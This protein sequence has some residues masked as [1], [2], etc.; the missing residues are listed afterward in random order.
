MLIKGDP[1]ASAALEEFNR[2]DL[3]GSFTA[4]PSD[5][6]IDRLQG[7]MGDGQHYVAAQVALFNSAPDLGGPVDIDGRLYLL[8]AGADEAFK[9][10]LVN[11]YAGHVGVSQVLHAKVEAEASPD[12]PEKA[13]AMR[14][15]IFD[16]FAAS[17][18]GEG[19]RLI[20]GYSMLASAENPQDHIGF[21]FAAIALIQEY[22]FMTRQVSLDGGLEQSE[23]LRRSRIQMK[24]DLQL[25]SVV[26]SEL[27]R[28]LPSLDEIADGLGVEAP[29]IEKL[30]EG[31]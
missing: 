16:R 10:S 28:Q 7:A 20:G 14:G 4:W 19:R 6:D 31:I 15:A 30:F 29:P 26:V 11:H 22:Q 23:E 21:A 24:P 2:P 5:Q 12:R 13:A 17:L 1:V 9:Q 3:L 25:E 27:F 8:E 18:A